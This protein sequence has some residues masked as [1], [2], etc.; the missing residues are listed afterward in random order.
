MDTTVKK[1]LLVDDEPDMLTINSAILE[2][3]GYKVFLAKDGSEALEV[4]NKNQLDLIILD[5]ML[6]KIDGYLICGML[7]RDNR[8]SSIPIIIVSARY[9]EQDKI[10][11]KEVGADDYI[12]KPFEPETLLSLVSSLFGNS[13]DMKKVLIAKSKLLAKTKK[14]RRVIER[15]R[16]NFRNKKKALS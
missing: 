10:K 14:P 15:K 13:I 12:T 11:A 1:I 16:K 9:D 6:P 3:F 7:K 5:L 2:I 4:V 8:Y